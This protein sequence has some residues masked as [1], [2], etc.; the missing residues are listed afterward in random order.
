MLIHLQA[1]HQV[2]IKLFQKSEVNKLERLQSFSQRNVKTKKRG[3]TKKETNRNVLLKTLRIITS[4]SNTTRFWISLL[5]GYHFGPTSKL[6]QNNYQPPKR[7]PAAWSSLPSKNFRAC[8]TASLSNPSSISL[9]T[10]ASNSTP[11][12]QNNPH[13]RRDL[14]ATLFVIWKGWVWPTKLCTKQIPH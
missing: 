8:I 14:Y 10:F 7:Y 9:E 13:L 5:C 6:E 1:T 12:A 2:A 4:Q 11:W 3:I